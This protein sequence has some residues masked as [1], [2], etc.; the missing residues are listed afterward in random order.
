[1][2]RGCRG[3]DERRVAER[4]MSLTDLNEFLRRSLT[5]RTQYRTMR[6][7]LLISMALC[8]TAW[9]L[10]WPQAAHAIE[11]IN[12]DDPY[13]RTLDLAPVGPGPL[14]LAKVFC[15]RVETNFRAVAMVS[16]DGRSIVYLQGGPGY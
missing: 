10:G 15:Q 1:M 12:C 5:L 14:E 16:P 9:C 3:G 2:L 13:Y 6:R 11:R 8:A 7:Q 4:R